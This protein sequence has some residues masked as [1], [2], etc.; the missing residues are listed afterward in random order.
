MRGFGHHPKNKKSGFVLVFYQKFVGNLQ[1]EKELESPF[2][3]VEEV[4]CVA[5]RART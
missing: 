1:R 5:N 4:S 3:G 2:V